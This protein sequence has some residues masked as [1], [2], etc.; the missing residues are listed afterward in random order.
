MLIPGAGL[1]LVYRGLWGDRSKGRTRC[2]KCWYDM[3]GSLP[4]L[5]CPECG[6][7]ARQERRLSKHHRRWGRIVIGA[8]L[9]LLPAYPLVTIGG[10]WREQAVL[11]KYKI[12]PPWIDDDYYVGPAWLVARLPDEFTRYFERQQYLYIVSSEQLAACRS[13]RY[14]Q[15]VRTSFSP[16]TDADIVHLQ[17]LPKLEH[18]DLWNTQVTDASLVH[19]KD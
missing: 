1:L 14:L 16:V 8:V 2:P 13:L 10:W 7:N 19:L 18:L 9:L 6:H 15:D 3:R 5:E 12:T 17:G 4:R 11:R